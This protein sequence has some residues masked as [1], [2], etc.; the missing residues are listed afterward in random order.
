MK[1]TFLLVLASTLLT[2]CLFSQGTGMTG[3]NGHSEAF[4]SELHDLTVDFSSDEWAFDLY[5]FYP[6]LEDYVLSIH[7]DAT[8][9][10]GTNFGDAAFVLT[11]QEVD[12][13]ETCLSFVTTDERT[14]GF[15]EDST[16]SFNGLSYY[17]TT[18]SGAAAGSLY[19]SKYFRVYRDGRCFQAAEVLH[20]TAIGNYDFAV[21]TEVN[22]EEVWAKLDS[23]METLKFE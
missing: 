7:L 20:T 13:L 14:S 11:S 12:S 1:K 21:V 4:Y 3:G 18:G 17:A 5:P 16:V 2:G 6:G 19:E 8:P 23:V 15:S 9:Y 10:E 22:V